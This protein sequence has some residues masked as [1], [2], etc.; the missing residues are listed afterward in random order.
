MQ[1]EIKG[2]GGQLHVE[3]FE[4]GGQAFPEQMLTL[5]VFSRGKLGRYPPWPGKVSVLL[6]N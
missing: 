6:L 1:M 3:R 2:G 4:G 5:Y